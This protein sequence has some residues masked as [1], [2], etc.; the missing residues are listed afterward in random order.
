MKKA[1]AVMLSILCI[2]SCFTCAVCA[3]EDPGLL[4]ML[5]PEEPL[6]FALVY[7]NQTFSDVSMMYQPN[8]SLSLEGPGYV[9]VTKDKPIA[10]DH[11]FVCW[12]DENGKYY[13]AGDK[14][15]VDGECT[16]YAVWEEK[17]DNYIRPVRVFICAML[18][19]KKLFDKA[20]GIFKDY[21]EFTEDRVEGMRRATTA[22]NTA[23]N[24]AKAEQNITI[25][26]ESEGKNQHSVNT[27]D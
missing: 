26:K 2:L 23:V 13:Y 9:T 17:K 8:P 25:R 22:F 5:E 12:K 14:Y 10:V 20:F 19:M 6:L 15:Y 18:T 7:K 21:R 1:I 27:T 24:A 4:G 11:D 3:L 16:L